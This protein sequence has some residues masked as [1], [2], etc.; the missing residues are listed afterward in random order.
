MHIPVLVKEAL[1]WL[2]IKADGV[3]VDATAGAAGHSCAILE[4]LTGGRLIA[5]DKDPRAI[6]IAQQR[7]SVYGR[8]VTL[9]RQ[10]DLR[11]VNGILAD[12]GL[13]QMQIDTPERGFSFRTAGPLDMRMEIGRAHV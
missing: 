8:R 9:L 13:S 5:L 1:E 12:L 2:A 7:L 6:E 3:Y 11:G 4:Q 10:M